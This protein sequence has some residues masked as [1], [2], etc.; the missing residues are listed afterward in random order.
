MIS[1]LSNIQD[2]I[3]NYA[4]AIS[5]I[6]GTD[7]EIIDESL[8]RI[9]GTGKYRHMLNEN[10][11]KNGYIYHH[12]LQVRETV[13]IKNPGEHPLCQLCEKHHYCSEMLDLNAPIFLNNRVIGVIGI[14]CSTQAQRDTLLSQI[15]KFVTFIEQIAVMIS[16]KVFECLERLR[17][18][19]TLGAFR[20][21][22]DAMDRGVVAIDGKGLI[23]HANHSADRILN[24]EVQGLPLTIETTG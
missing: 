5:G 1:V 24:R 6:T 15:D 8:M 21:L 11:A 23:W 22:I 14:I 7:V 2:D 17:A 20:R 16:S 12:V 13:L 4:D 3:C 18:Q 10:V 9:A 19:E